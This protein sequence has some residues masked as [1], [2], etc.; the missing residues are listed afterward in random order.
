MGKEQI[1]CAPCSMTDE[2]RAISR[3]V[4]G[5]PD[6]RD[7]GLA[8]L[9]RDQEGRMDNME[10]VVFGNGQPGIKK[11]LDELAGNFEQ[12]SGHMKTSAERERKKWKHTAV[13]AGVCGTAVVGGGQA[14]K[15][16]EFVSVLL[17]IL[18]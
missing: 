10:T 11:R 9:S 1:P 5:S 18:F 3:A 8:E 15:I 14:D 17:K 16:I 12:I 2:I 13:V 7:P 4:C 6:G